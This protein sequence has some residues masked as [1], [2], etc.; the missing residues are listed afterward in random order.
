M[1]DWEVDLEMRLHRG[2]SV[3]CSRTSWCSVEKSTEANES[4]EVTGVRV[5]EG[6]CQNMNP[7]EEA[8]EG[9]GDA[10]A[11]VATGVLED[12]GLVA[13]AGAGA[14]LALAD[15]LGK[16]CDFS[17]FAAFSPL[18]RLLSLSP[19]LRRRPATF[20]AQTT[21]LETRVSSESTDS[22]R[23]GRDATKYLWSSWRAV[24]WRPVNLRKAI[25]G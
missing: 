10:G 18:N 22:V 11:V 25:A 15:A 16:L 19:N 5:S 6:S 9:E 24:L 4:C 3:S 21:V 7:S 14:A 8:G 2:T 13:G 20:S 23:P 12:T 17:A 1:D